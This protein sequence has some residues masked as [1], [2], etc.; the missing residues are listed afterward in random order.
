M[1]PSTNLRQSRVDILAG[2]DHDIRHCA[3]G[4]AALDEAQIA[5][6]YDPA[7]LFIAWSL[8]PE[9]MIEALRALDFRALTRQAV[10]HSVEMERRFGRSFHWEVVRARWMALLFETRES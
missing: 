5:T 3:A 10:A 9:G 2:I 4:V 7:D 8:D 6:V 1:T